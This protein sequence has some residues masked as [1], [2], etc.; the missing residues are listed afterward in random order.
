MSERDAPH[1][2]QM[3][4]KDRGERGRGRERE[5]EERERERAGGGDMGSAVVNL[6]IMKRI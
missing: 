5:R 3:A 1:A 2:W 6:V 4:N